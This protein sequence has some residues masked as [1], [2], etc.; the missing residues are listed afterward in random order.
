MSG[1]YAPFGQI[2]C[3]CLLCIRPWMECWIFQAN[4]VSPVPVWSWEEDGYVTMAQCCIS[5][6]SHP[7]DLSHG[8]KKREM[9][10][11][12]YYEHLKIVAK[13]LGVV[14]SQHTGT[15]SCNSENTVKSWAFCHGKD[16][17]H[18]CLAV[19]PVVHSRALPVSCF[20]Y[21]WGPWLMFGL[22]LAF[23]SWK[24]GQRYWPVS[25]A[26]EILSAFP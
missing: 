26:L 11:T 8:S 16:Q 18:I 14:K 3:E 25:L 22:I 1:K 7:P 2:L 6:L 9:T 20:S 23:V 12:K 15:A 21:S 13:C 10:Y 5:S 17:T 4:P 24:C 19:R